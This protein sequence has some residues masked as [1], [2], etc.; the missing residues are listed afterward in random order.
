MAAALKIL[1][2]EIALK[3]I[4]EN[5]LSPEMIS[6]FPAAAGGPKWLVLGHLDRYL[7]SYWFPADQAPVLGVGASA[8]AWRLACLA[9]NDPV[10]AIDRFEAAYVDQHY[11]SRPTAAEVSREGQ[12]ILAAIMQGS[13]AQQL[14]QHPWLRINVIAARCRA[15]TGHPNSG[16]QA[17]GLAGAVL[18]NTLHRRGLGLSFERLIAH[19]QRR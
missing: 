13:D 3:R 12:R 18:L 14:L 15:W 5:G 7:F 4:R 10:A 6:H 1:A 8:G 9:Q 17:V 11:A 2:G 19:H 16:L